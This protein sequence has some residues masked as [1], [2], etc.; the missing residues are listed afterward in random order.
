MQKKAT[1]KLEN[2]GEEF[3]GELKLLSVASMYVGGAPEQFGGLKANVVIAQFLQQIAYPKTQSVHW[4]GSVT[5][6]KYSY[7]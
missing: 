7:F 4:A 1:G 5:F 3:R 6:P 2:F